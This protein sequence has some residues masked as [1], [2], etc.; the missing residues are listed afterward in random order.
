MFNRRAGCWVYPNRL[1]YPQTFKESL[2]THVDT[3]SAKQHQ[4]PHLNS[5]LHKI[6]ALS[7]VCARRALRALRVLPAIHALHESDALHVVHDLHAW[8]A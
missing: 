3:I 2:K 5:E 4:V 8:H 7:A 1:Q 6:H